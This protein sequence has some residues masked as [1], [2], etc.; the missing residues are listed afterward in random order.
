MSA[1]REASLADVQAAVAEEERTGG[2]SV[3][4]AETLFRLFYGAPA[5]V[6]LGVCARALARY[7]PTSPRARADELLADPLAWVARHGREIPDDPPDL[8][9]G[10]AAF[11]GA[12]DGLLILAAH[13]TEPRLAT[14]AACVAL[15]SAV[16]AEALQTW[17]RVDR[18]AVDLWRR[19]N[20]DDGEIED[21][22]ESDALDPSR[23]APEIAAARHQRW[24]EILAE[25]RTSHIASAAGPDESA[26][27][28]DLAEW[29]DHEYLLIAPPRRS[30]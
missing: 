5:D 21:L 7:R 10:D 26:L 1:P 25:L 19:L 11:Q 12:L 17:E 14:P 23:Q 4:L 22:A 8:G 2:G 16:H 27:A 6:V 13:G 24:Q 28:A 9:P 30:K 20:T 29:R 18:A 3:S 15:M